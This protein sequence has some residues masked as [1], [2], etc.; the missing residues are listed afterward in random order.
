MGNRREPG[1]ETLEAEKIRAITSHPAS[2]L[3][4]QLSIPLPL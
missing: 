1:K 3:N 2:R 4:Y